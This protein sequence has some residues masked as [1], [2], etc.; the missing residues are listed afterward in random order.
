M[1]MACRVGRVVR[2]ASDKA[3]SH[4]NPLETQ[5]GPCL[6][7]RETCTRP[8]SLDG[9]PPSPDQAAPVGP[10]GRFELKIG[11]TTRPRRRARVARVN[12][13]WRRAGVALFDEFVQLA[14]HASQN[15]VPFLIM[16][17]AIEL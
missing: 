7:L 2:L 16:I 1:P 6:C 4:D 3:Q 5:L 15:R 8:E 14:R 10:M 9:G 13:C 11:P 17:A 12:S